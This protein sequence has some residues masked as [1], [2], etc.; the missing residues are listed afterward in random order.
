[1]LNCK[2]SSIMLWT[3]VFA[4]QVQSKHKIQINKCVLANGT[5]SFQE[6]PCENIKIKTKLSTTNQSKKKEA[7][8]EANINALA[9]N[10]K[11]INYRNSQLNTN[12]LTYKSLNKDNASDLIKQ[13]I[14]HKVGRYQISITVHKD[15]EKVSKVYSNKLLHMKFIDRNPNNKI[16]LLIDFIFPDNKKFTLQELTNLINLIGSRYVAGSV[17]HRVNIYKLRVKQGLGVMTTF[18]NS[19]IVKDYQY[20]SKGAI[21]KNDWMIQFTLLSDGIN[22]PNHNFALHSL[23]ETIIIQN[24]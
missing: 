1:M 2:V 10:K 7:V 24:K 12:Y 21:F 13:L 3:L 8:K 19:Q 23:M 6:V 11:T 4:A 22:N 5:I 9:K 16:S 17:E 18:T 20:A 14:S 15:W